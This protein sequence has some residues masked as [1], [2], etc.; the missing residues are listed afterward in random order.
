M[1]LPPELDPDRLLTQELPDDLTLGEARAF[2]MRGSIM[3]QLRELA[4]RK[5]VRVRFCT[6]D[7]PPRDLPD[8]MTLDAFR[9]LARGK[10]ARI[11]V[12]DGEGGAVAPVPA[13][14]LT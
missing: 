6:M 5:R 9:V 10:R 4:S 2:M 14:E 13:P 12:D 8:E 11:I 1:S 7:E 3:T